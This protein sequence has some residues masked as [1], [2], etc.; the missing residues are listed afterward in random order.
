[1]IGSIDSVQSTVMGHVAWT[2]QNASGNRGDDLR[3]L[4]QCDLQPYKLLH[5]NMETIIPTVLGLQDEHKAIKNGMQT[6]SSFAHLR[7]N[8][9]CVIQTVNPTYMAFIAHRNP[10]MC[11][12][13]AIA[14][15][16]HWLH[17]YYKLAEHI[18]IDWAQNSSWRKVLIYLTSGAEN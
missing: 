13:G 14:I 4:K 7:C 8:S 11:P 16:L 1:M 18:D 6:M 10:V 3:S 12:L 2:C 17:D 15:Y 9:Q 5:P